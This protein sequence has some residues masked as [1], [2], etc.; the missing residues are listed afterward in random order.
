MQF[1]YY[2]GGFRQNPTTGAP[3]NPGTYPNVLKQFNYLA[4][5]AYYNNAARFSVFGKFEGRKI[6]G[7]YPGAV[8][9]GNNQY[10]LAFGAKYYLAPFNLLNFALQYERN[11]FTDTDKSP[12]P[13]Q[14]STNSVTF[15]MQLLLY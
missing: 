15:Q 14:S 12:T 8:Q 7:D 13:Q 6:S 5:A 1:G 4:E 10:W 11:H 9:A 3:T 2:D